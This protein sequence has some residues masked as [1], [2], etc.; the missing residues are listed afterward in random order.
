LIK[1]KKTTKPGTRFPI[2]FMYGNQKQHSFNLP[3]E[4]KWDILHKSKKPPDIGNSHTTIV[5]TMVYGALQL[6]SLRGDI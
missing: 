4:P 6:T 1:N 5:T 2:L 3:F